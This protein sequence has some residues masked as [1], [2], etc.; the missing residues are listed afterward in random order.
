M[1]NH[2][3]SVWDDRLR[4]RLCQL[5]DE[6]VLSA[7]QI[8]QQLGVS[9]NSVVSQRRRLKLPK[10]LVPEPLR[11]LKPAVCK[12]PSAPR[13]RPPPIERPLPPPVIEQARPCCWP[14]WGMERPKQYTFCDQPAAP[15]RPYCRRHCAVAYTKIERRE[16]RYEF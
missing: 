3:P 8:G 13:R 5:W 10:R 4:T 1:R 14:L 9:K 11:K 12:P 6:G 15:A 16:Q 2:V 7:S